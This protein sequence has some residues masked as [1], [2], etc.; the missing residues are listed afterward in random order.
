[1]PIID[2]RTMMLSYERRIRQ[3]MLLEVIERLPKLSSR[4]SFDGGAVECLRASALLPIDE[5]GKLEAM[6][7][8]ARGIH[9][10]WTDVRTLLGV[11]IR[12][13]EY[14]WCAT[15]WWRKCL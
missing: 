15:I 11:E 6:K 8:L 10:K 7:A 13:E 4:P 2:D 9:E 5:R 14:E 1:M 12:E 3:K